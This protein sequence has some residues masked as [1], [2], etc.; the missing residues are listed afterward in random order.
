MDSSLFK[1]YKVEDRS[2]ISLIK[3]EIHHLV[4]PRFSEKRTG[5]IDIIVSELASNLV[6]HTAGGEL[7]YRVFHEKDKP[8]FEILSIDNGPGMND[9]SRFIKDGFST[10]NT[11]GQG[12]GSINRL[13]NFSQIY[14]KENWGTIF[15]V[16][17]MENA[18]EKISPGPIVIRC[19]SIAKPGEMVSGDGCSVRVLN[20]KICIMVA[21]GLGHGKHA[22]TATDVAIKCFQNSTDVTPSNLIKEMH[23]DLKKTRGVVATIAIMDTENEKVDLCGVGNINTRIY[24]GIE[25]KN[26]VTHNGVIGMNLPSRLENSILDLEKYQ[27]LIFCSDGIKTKWNLVQYTSILKYDPMI[28]AAAIYKDQA[29]HT[30]DMTIV[31]AK[32][33]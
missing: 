22:K 18:G 20:K 2:Y 15:Y 17:C 8:V 26:Y 7:V 19:F 16:R 13:S 25:H 31:T 23:E 9:V 10:S 30:D 4:R 14:S 6:K 21:D 11:L 5:E 28:L 3:R 33:V 32:F 24:K 27:Q 1:S 29:R 12:I